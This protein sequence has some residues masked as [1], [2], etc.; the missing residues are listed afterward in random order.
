MGPGE[1]LALARATRAAL[2]EANCLAEQMAFREA[3]RVAREAVTDC[4]ALKSW[5]SRWPLRILA[6]TALAELQAKLLIGS[7]KIE[8]V[9]ALVAQAASAR[10]RDGAD[11]FR[12]DGHAEARRI[13]AQACKQ[14]ANPAIVAAE[15]KCAAEIERR[16]AFARQAEAARKAAE[17]SRYR[18]P[19][20]TTARLWPCSTRPNCEG[21]SRNARRAWTASTGTKPG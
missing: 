4:L 16:M 15:R 19:W 11:P 2:A 9:D 5:S 1:I 20:R 18:E 7:E 10:E 17:G 21:P 8:T 12:W 3:V 14:I 6:G 13:L